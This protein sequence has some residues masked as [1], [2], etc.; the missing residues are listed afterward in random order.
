MGQPGL[1]SKTGP[2]SLPCASRAPLFTFVLDA[3][4]TFPV[5]LDTYHFPVLN[6][7]PRSRYVAEF[8]CLDWISSC[9]PQSEC[10]LIFLQLSTIRSHNSSYWKNPPIV[11]YLNAFYLAI[12]PQESCH[13]F[14][15][16]LF[17]PHTMSCLN[18]CQIF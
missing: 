11:R 10:L 7:R 6:P 4:S 17:P 3:F 16:L 8:T 15:L 2:F 1:D 5:S 18:L 14:E 13:C 12:P 9:L